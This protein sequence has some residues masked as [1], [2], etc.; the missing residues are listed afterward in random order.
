MKLRMELGSRSYDIIL[1]RGALQNAAKLG[2]LNR[3]VMIVSDTGVPEQYIKTLIPQC[4]SA[5]VHIVPQ[6][7]ASKSVENWAAIQQHMMEEGFGRTDAVAALG[8]GVVGDLAGFAASTYMRGVDYFGIPTTTLSQIDSSIGGKTAIDLGGTKNIV[9]SFHQPKLVVVDPDTLKTLS[10][11]HYIN[12]LA[13]ALKTGLI[14]SSE[15]FNIFENEDIDEN[16]ERILY[17]CLRYKKGVVERDETEQ[18]ER[19]LLNLGHTIGHGIEAAGGMD[20]LLHGESIA[21]GMLPMIE[22]NTLRKRTRAVMRKLGLPL[23][24]TYDN[25]KILQYLTH[26]KK[27]HNDIYTIVKVKV[28]G[29]GYLEK[30]PYEELELM[31]KGEVE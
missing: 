27:R 9:G 28:P 25:D 23:T 31:V 26:D 22:S 30:V 3:K 4:A 19:K 14:G 6:G 15:L 20:G 11:R 21:I 13:E 5:Y 8:G 10:H 18:G 16:I 2:D 7:E 29:H 24:H 1:K 12:G 17:L